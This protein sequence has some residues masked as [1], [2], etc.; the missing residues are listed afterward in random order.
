MTGYDLI[1]RFQ[2]SL[3]GPCGVADGDSVLVCVS[4]GMDS[5][6]LLDLMARVAPGLRLR[7]GVFHAEHGL[8][9]DA[10]LADAEFVAKRC[11]ELAVPVYVESLAM[12]PGD[13]N[14][15][16]GARIRRYAAALACM[17]RCGFTW[18]ATAHT[19][20]DQAETV[21]YRMARGTGIRGLAGMRHRREDGIIRPL[22]DVSRMEVERYAHQRGIAYCHDETNREEN[23][24]RNLIRHS[25]MPLL[26]RINPG[27]ARALCSLARIAFEEGS[28]LED[29]ARKAENSAVVVSG[30][31]VRILAVER[32]A[33]LGE[34]V[35]KRVLI[36]AV[37]SMGADER[38]LA[39]AQVEKLAA[40]VKGGISGHEVA[41]KVRVARKGDFLVVQR[42]A[43]Q[44][45]YCRDLPSACHELAIPE[46]GWTVRI[47]ARMGLCG[48]AVVR[49]WMPGDRMRGARVSEILA[50]RGVPAA[51]RPLWPV[52]AAGGDVVAV[53]EGHSCAAE[54]V[55]NVEA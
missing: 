12:S 32:L 19:L 53:A 1:W 46:T 24:A 38:G 4:G 13:P 45:L 8:R 6:V 31:H 44:P 26:Q 17:H 25:V 36:N 3:V 18:A 40:V 20:D 41:R 35:L 28:V 54:L 52:L 55:L 9:G 29:L 2:D 43:G 33:E 42:I 37:T 5:M 22:L 39:M 21:L 34:A 48:G 47:V 30:T 15:E 16:E 7:I 11:R 10:S 23:R 27:V 51:M 50:H 49:S 14:L